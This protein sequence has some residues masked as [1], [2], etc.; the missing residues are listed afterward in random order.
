[1]FLY[2]PKLLTGVHDL[3]QGR[4]R[5]ARGR[6]RAAGRHRPADRRRR[7]PTGSAPTRVL[8]VSLH[9]GR[10]A[11]ARARRGLRRRWSPLT[12]VCLTM[13]SRS[14]SARAR[15]SSSCPEWFPDRV[16]AVTGVVGAAGGSAASSRRSSWAS[17]SRPPG[18]Y[19][20]GFVLMALVALACLV[21]LRGLRERTPAGVGVGSRGAQRA[22]S[23]RIAPANCAG[24]GVV[25]LDVAG[26]PL[27]RRAAV[28]REGVVF[29]SRH[30]ATRTPHLRRRAVLVWSGQTRPAH[31]A[32][33]AELVAQ[34]VGDRA[35]CRL[36]RSPSRKTSTRS[37]QNATRPVSSAASGSGCS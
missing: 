7:S 24:K 12:I 37:S 25:G 28:V 29:S 20:L 26:G 19:A 4:R 9:R 22:R 17:S 2:L 16:G 5:R 18:G 23:R 15:C 34:R 31:L 35:A 32:L 36:R 11:R 6:L 27:D 1:M 21:V 13:A 3:T 14:A 8:L 10:R 30:S 33:H